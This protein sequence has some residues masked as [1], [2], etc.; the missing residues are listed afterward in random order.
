MERSRNSLW[1]FAAAMLA[2]ATFASTLGC[3]GKDDNAQRV[4]DGGL[5]DVQT[6]AGAASA[7]VP[8]GPSGRPVTVGP[9]VSRA[10]RPRVW[11]VALVGLGRTP[12]SQL[13]LAASYLTKT[14]AEAPEF[15][16]ETTSMLGVLDSLDSYCQ[17]QWLSAKTGDRYRK[18]AELLL[19]DRVYLDSTSGD[20]SVYMG[21][22]LEA[23]KKLNPGS[24]RCGGHT[25]RHDPTERLYSLTIGGALT[26]L[27][28]GLALDRRVP[29]SLTEFPFLGFP[30]P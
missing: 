4:M 27:D 1:G 2:W 12:E 28:D 29:V 10:G 8:L 7:G 20:C 6:E 11:E 16:A 14:P 22:E 26:G 3:E 24:G 13:S 9:Q 21:V 17:N 19:D 15:L 18:L 23:L 30:N 25:P 5:S